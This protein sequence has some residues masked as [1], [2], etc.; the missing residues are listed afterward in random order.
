MEIY[1]A[2]RETGTLIEECAS[3]EDAKRL[4]VEYEEQDKADCVY[5]PDFYDIVDENHCSIEY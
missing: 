3:I 1:V 4:I 5:E 2:D